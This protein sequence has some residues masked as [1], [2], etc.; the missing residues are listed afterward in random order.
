[1]NGFYK[2]L[3]DIKDHFLA[4]GITN[5]VSY[6]DDSKM[7]LNK[8]SIFP[9]VHLDINRVE[10]T[11]T[12]IVFTIYVLCVGLIDQDWV[13]E[14]EDEFF[15]GNNDQDVMNEQLFVL[16]G[17]VESLRRGDLYR[18]NV[19]LYVQPTAQPIGAF[20]DSQVAGWASEIQVAIPKDYS[21]C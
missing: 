18:N 5:T 3:D 20:D 14:S 2:V 6:G 21:I 16:T 4:N 10:Y 17:L 8:T 9:L 7:D 13:E 19:R 12:S 15:T 1:M 11:D